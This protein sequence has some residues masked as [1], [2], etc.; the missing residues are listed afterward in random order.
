MN[1]IIKK[2]VIS[3]FSLFLFIVAQEMNSYAMEVQSTDNSEFITS[4]ISREATTYDYTYYDFTIKKGESYEITNSH[5][6]LVPVLTNSCDG[7]FK[8][9]DA[10][11]RDQLTVPIDYLTDGYLEAFGLFPYNSVKITAL[12]DDIWVS[13][14]VDIKNSIKKTTI[15]TFHKFSIN[16]NDNYEF[17]STTN[18]SS[19]VIITSGKSAKIDSVSYDSNESFIYTQGMINKFYTFYGK[20]KTRFTLV[21]GTNVNVAI[22]YEDKNT[23][24]KVSTP[25]IHRVISKGGETYEFTNKL[26]SQVRLAKT[27]ETSKERMEYIY[28]NSDGSIK[29]SSPSAYT[30]L[31]IDP[32]KKYK[33]TTNNYTTYFVP[34]EMKNNI[35]R[36]STRCFYSNKITAG[37]TY[38]FKNKSPFGFVVSTDS[39][40]IGALFNY[41][42]Y[43]EVGK[44]LRSGSNYSGDIYLNSTE[45]VVITLS[46]GS[47]LNIYVPSEFRYGVTAEYI[48]I[49]NHFGVKEIKWFSS[50]GYLDKTFSY[51]RPNDSITRA[52]F[53][54]MVN[55]V[56]GFK[57][58]VASSPFGDVSSN[59]WYYREVLIAVENGYISTGN[60]NFR[61]NDPITRQEVANIITSIT[62]TKDRNLDKLEKYTDKHLVSDSMKSSVEGA[63]EQNF[64]GVGSNTFNPR[65]NITRGEAVVTLTRVIK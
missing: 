9:A 5:P 53:V 35:T 55:G 37:Y 11:I 44:F 64:M 59:H 43:D 39:A 21:D 42:I 7:N 65:K 28:Y 40:S 6:F 38:K 3:L 20:D 18:N 46:K 29:Y 45:T 26:N 57:N 23:L 51:F 8:K 32:G 12:T 19:F 60:E 17:T 2:F 63:I 10:L 31:S 4:K 49:S 52:E 34:Y 62:K 61:P 1:K 50:Q 13:V 27:P 47:G 41:K 58:S 25:A 48:D 22:P 33:I 30:S 54:K 56:F 16:K 14:P 24:K 15:P 36:S